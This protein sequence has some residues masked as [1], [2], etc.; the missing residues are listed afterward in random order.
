MK[1]AGEIGDGNRGRKSGEIGGNRGQT[2]RFLIF[3]GLVD[4]LGLYA[5]G[6]YSSTGS[7]IVSGLTSGLTIRITPNK[8][9]CFV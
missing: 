8:K 3:Y 9:S 2:G 7:L 1:S 4:V 5:Q 6:S